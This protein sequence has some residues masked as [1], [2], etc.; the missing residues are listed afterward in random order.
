[1]PDSVRVWIREK[2]W[3]SLIAF[4]REEEKSMRDS[5][6]LPG[7]EDETWRAE[8]RRAHPDYYRIYKA[9]RKAIARG[10]STRA[11]GRRR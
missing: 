10:C 11:P 8:Y 6:G 3:E 7:R 5:Y 1:M 4:F 2:D 9:A